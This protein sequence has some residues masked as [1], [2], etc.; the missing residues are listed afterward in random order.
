M[1]PWGDIQ[2]PPTIATTILT[3]TIISDAILHIIGT[4]NY[5]THNIISVN[6]S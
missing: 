3:L 1:Y 4:D 5:L 6:H 2:L